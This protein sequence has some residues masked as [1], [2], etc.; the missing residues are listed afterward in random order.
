M[1]KTIDSSGK[2]QVSGCCPIFDAVS[3]R[4]RLCPTLD[5]VL[6][7]LPTSPLQ[8]SFKDFEKTVVGLED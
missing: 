6:S 3:A 2:G 5:R 4:W 1:I 8:V 7:P